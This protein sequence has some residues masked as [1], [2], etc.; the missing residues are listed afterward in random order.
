MLS[1]EALAEGMGTTDYAAQMVY[2]LLWHGHYTCFLPPNQRLPM[3]WLPDCLEAILGVMEAPDE[4]L[5]RRVYNVQGLSFTPALLFQ[6]IRRRLR[7]VGGRSST[8]PISEQPLP[9][10]GHAL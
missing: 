8:N 2:N 1:G 9:L 10:P 7:L 5:T 6:A 4:A 3:I